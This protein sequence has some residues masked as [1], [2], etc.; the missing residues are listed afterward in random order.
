MVVSFFILCSSFFYF[1]FS[2]YICFVF[3]Y[4]VGLCLFG[5]LISALGE[6]LSSVGVGAHLRTRTHTHSLTYSQ[7]TPI[8]LIFFQENYARP[9]ICCCD[10]LRYD[11]RRFCLHS[12]VALFASC[13]SPSSFSSPAISDFTFRA[14]FYLASDVI[15]CV[16]NTLFSHLIDF[17][18]NRDE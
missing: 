12:M 7:R 10:A 18:S 13:S 11:G 9:R 14:R 8:Y 2:I 5:W 4:C 15:E 6:S 1:L 17:P 16:N 3:S